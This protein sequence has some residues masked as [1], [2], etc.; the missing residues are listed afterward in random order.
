MLPIHV[1]KQPSNTVVMYIARSYFSM[2]TN[3]RYCPLLVEFSTHHSV[4]VDKA[5]SRVRNP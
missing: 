1:K 5:V 3:C 2:P 4:D